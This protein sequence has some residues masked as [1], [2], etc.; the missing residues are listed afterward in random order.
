MTTTIMLVILALMT[1]SMLLASIRLVR[2]P[3][4][5]DQVVALDLLAISGI[6][7]MSTAAILYDLES[8]LDVGIL[9]GLVGFIATAAFATY[10]EKGRA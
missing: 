7:L 6:A 8:L 1:L 2:G 10:I 9:I 4:L 3:T 5:A